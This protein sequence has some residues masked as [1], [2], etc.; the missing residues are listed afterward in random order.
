M[1]PEGQIV[2]MPLK[3]EYW[4]APLEVKREKMFPIY[5]ENQNSLNGWIFISRAYN[6]EHFSCIGILNL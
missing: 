1:Q 4:P 2:V 5:Q 3:D 6:V